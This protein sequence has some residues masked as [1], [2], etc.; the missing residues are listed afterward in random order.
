[1][2]IAACRRRRRRDRNGRDVTAGHRG[3]HPRERSR[4]SVRS[5]IMS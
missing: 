3:A 1:M 2:T 4:T 5:R